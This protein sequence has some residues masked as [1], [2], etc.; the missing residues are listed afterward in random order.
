VVRGVATI[1]SIEIL[2]ARTAAS[3]LGLYLIR[4][5]CVSTTR[6]GDHQS[7]PISGIVVEVTRVALDGDSAD[8]AQAVRSYTTASSI[9][10]GRKLLMAGRG[11]A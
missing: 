1:T 3:S 10:N 9:S 11:H 7:V 8:M 2:C 4:R 6:P 5:S